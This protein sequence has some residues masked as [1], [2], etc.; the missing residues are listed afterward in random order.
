MVDVLHIRWKFSNG[1]CEGTQA[2][3]TDDSTLIVNGDKT[4]YQ[5]TFLV[6][7]SAKVEP[8]I[9]RGDTAREC[10]AV[11][12]TERD[13][14]F[15]HPQSVEEMTMT[16]QR[17]DQTRRRIGCPADRREESVAIR[18]RQDHT[19]M[20]V[21]KPARAL[22]GEIAGGKTGDRHRLLNHL[23]A[24]GARPNSSR[25]D[26][27][28]RLSNAGFLR[29]NGMTTLLS[30]LRGNA[31]Y[32]IRATARPAY[33]PT[34]LTRIVVQKENAG[35]VNTRRCCMRDELLFAAVSTLCCGTM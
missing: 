14:R 23:F 28:S 5:I 10:R 20:L 18:S 26:L 12:L 13:N 33:A 32:F 17:L 16:L 29:A 19:L 27:Y 11:M 30:F 3:E 2:I 7:S 1:E 6:L 24:D 4:A 25:W 34:P 9:E 31:P 35:L 8:I 15:D 22:I 21:E